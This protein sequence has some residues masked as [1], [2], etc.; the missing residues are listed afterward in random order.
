M[1]F[2]VLC[3]GLLAFGL[4][5]L[6]N[7]QALLKRKYGDKEIPKQDIRFFRILGVVFVC[8]FLLPFLIH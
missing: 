5:C 1:I 8:L 6:I 3:L 4:L 2:L 7:P